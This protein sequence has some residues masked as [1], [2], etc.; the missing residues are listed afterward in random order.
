MLCCK[1][2]SWQTDHMALSK[3]WMLMNRNPSAEV[4]LCT[5]LPMEYNYTTHNR[6]FFLMSGYYGVRA[7]RNLN[8]HRFSSRLLYKHVQ[9]GAKIPKHIRS[10]CEVI[11]RPLIAH[12]SFSELKAHAE[13]WKHNHSIHQSVILYLESMFV[14]TFLCRKTHL[15]RIHLM[16]SSVH[17]IISSLLHLLSLRTLACHLKQKKNITCL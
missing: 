5:N 17:W 14:P 11:R 12:W 10:F 9:V 8:I 13:F 3:L 6:V 7:I 2:G 15:F 16:S 4:C 1:G